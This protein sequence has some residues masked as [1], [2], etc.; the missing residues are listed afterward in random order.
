MTADEAKTKKIHLFLNLFFLL[1]IIA[2]VGVSFYKYYY[3]K[4]YNYRVE[5]SCDPQTEQCSHRDCT[6]GSCPPNNLSD[7]KV[8]LVK[9]Y[10]FPKCSDNSCEKECV[11]GVISCTPVSCEV[12]GNCA[13]APKPQVQK[14][15]IATSTA[16]S[17]VATSTKKKNR[18]YIFD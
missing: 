12:E 6:D 4:N 13:P 1:T 7:Y 5:A 14:V 2:A 10:D 16:T 18:T 8:Y 17:T 15:E 9:A 3:T 11:R